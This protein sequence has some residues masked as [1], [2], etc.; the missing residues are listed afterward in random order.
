MFE[1]RKLES[2]ELLTG[3]NFIGG[4]WVESVSGSRFE[5]FGKLRVAP[6]DGVDLT[7]QTRLQTS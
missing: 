5:V 2:P 3:K 4:Q 1:T 6:F 7:I